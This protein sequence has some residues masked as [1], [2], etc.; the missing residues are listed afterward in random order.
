VK[1]AGYSTLV[2]KC[3]CDG[4]TY[5]ISPIMTSL[6]GLRVVL[7]WGPTPADLDSHIVFP[8]NHVFWEQKRGEEGR[9]SMSTT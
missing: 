5:A 3:P 8:G 1:K 7:N 6:D 2:A 4:M 9:P